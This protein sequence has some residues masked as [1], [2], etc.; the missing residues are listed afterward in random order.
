MKKM[1]KEY[2]VKFI[3]ADEVVD[4]EDYEQLIGNADDFEALVISHGAENDE[5]ALEAVSEEKRNA[6]IQVNEET[7]NFEFNLVGLKKFIKV[8][9]ADNVFLTDKGDVYEVSGK[10][11]P[12]PVLINPT[13]PTDSTKI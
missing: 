8:E 6:L 11:E 1:L 12:V 4:R 2:E 10:G 5:L 13:Q 9:G 7:G 3:A